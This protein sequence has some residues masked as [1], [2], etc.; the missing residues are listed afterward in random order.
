[1]EVIKTTYQHAVDRGDTN[2]YFIDGP[3]LM[4]IAKGDG[5]IDGCHP[6]DLGYYSMASAITEVLEKI[7][8]LDKN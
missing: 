7:Y 3:T 6:T 4:A 2:V 1:M 8:I 5:T